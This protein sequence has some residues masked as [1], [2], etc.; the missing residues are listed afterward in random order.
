MVVLPC[1]HAVGSRAKSSSSKDTQPKTEVYKWRISFTSHRLQHNT[2]V[3]INDKIL[4]SFCSMYT[5]EVRSDVKILEKQC[6]RYQM[7]FLGV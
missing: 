1:R 3:K 2:E 5:M 7:P 6:N 4:Y